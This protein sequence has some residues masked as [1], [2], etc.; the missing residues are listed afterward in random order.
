MLLYLLYNSIGVFFGI[1]ARY[2]LAN[3]LNKHITGTWLDNI[4]GAILLAIVFRLYDNDII[5][6][7]LWFIIGVGFSGAYTTFST[8]GKETLTLILEKQYMNAIIYVV[9]SFLL[10]KIGRASCRE[11]V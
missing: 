3:K 10:S 4:S 5:T 2:W 6:E 1:I 8:F 11:R 7:S 9:S